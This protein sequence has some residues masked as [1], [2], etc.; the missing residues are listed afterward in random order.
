MKLD[1]WRNL[2]GSKF[3]TPEPLLVCYAEDDTAQ[4][5]IRYPRL[6]LG[7]RG[8]GNAGGVVATATHVREGFGD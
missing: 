6:F 1:S 8:L 3:L 7:R 4:Q 5:R 2:H